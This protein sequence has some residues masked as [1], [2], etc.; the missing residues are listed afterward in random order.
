MSAK[1]NSDA[2]LW[3][4]SS[5][6][7]RH[8]C[9][10]KYYPQPDGTLMLAAV[11]EFSHPVFKE[12]GWE[13]TKPVPETYWLHLGQLEAARERGDAVAYKH[14]IKMLQLYE[15][16]YF[17]EGELVTTK[18]VDFDDCPRILAAVDREE[19]RQRAIRR[20]KNQCF[21]YFMSNHD[22][23]TFVTLT[24]DPGIV[25]SSSYDD[26]YN[27]CLRPWLSNRVQRRGLKYILIP[28]YHRDGEKIHFHAVMNSS[29]LKLT[30][31]RYPNG[32]LIKRHGKQ[33]YN[34]EDWSYGF[35]TA[36]R[37]E[38]DS[39]HV[40]VCKYIFKYMGKQ[41]NLGARIGGRYYLHGGDLKRPRFVYADTVDELCVPTK[42]LYKREVE[43]PCGVTYASYSFV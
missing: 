5:A 32:R 27:G 4:V 19:T 31:A 1:L 13:E 38:G 26:V 17:D 11:E 25:N 22:L 7:V 23:D 9:R 20:A 3:G 35:T 2:P 36:E 37:I 15:R 43:V 12:A 10:A 18:S 40:K 6:H 24:F 33:V 42:A 39:C 8:K 16:E 41:I 28:E 29:A 34:V 21:D 14:H 30:E